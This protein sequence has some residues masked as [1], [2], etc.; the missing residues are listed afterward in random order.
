MII[1]HA[2][3]LDGSLTLWGEDSDPPPPRERPSGVHHP[4]CARASR[5]AKAVGIAPKDAAGTE[6]E[7][8]VWLPSQGNS[9]IPSEAL[10]G[11]ALKS[12]AKLRI[13]PWRVPILRLS[14][15][16]AIKLLQRC[17]D[18]RVLAPGMALS[19]DVTYWRH[20]MLFAANLTARQQ[21][22]PNVAQSQEKTKAVWTPLY[23][24][25]D[26][27]RLAE[28]AKAMPAPVRATTDA[29]DHR[30]PHRMPSVDLG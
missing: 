30:P 11:P 2:A 24:G 21:F 1:I 28:L 4:R 25:D 13:K 5:L 17:Q 22:L 18:G 7:A 8:T 3:Q 6:V 27:N 26:A 14:S 20:V 9:P 19:P 15:G 12:R 29:L 16:Q 10:A 23:I